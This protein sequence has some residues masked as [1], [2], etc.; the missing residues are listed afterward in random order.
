MELEVGRKKAGGGGGIYLLDPAEGVGR[1]GVAPVGI[2]MRKTR[3]EIGSYLGLKLET[4]SRTMSKFHD[5]ELIE[6]KQK[7]VHILNHPRLQEAAR[8]APH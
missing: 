6:V 5:E 4:V 7:A 2:G 8:R 1:E 3:E